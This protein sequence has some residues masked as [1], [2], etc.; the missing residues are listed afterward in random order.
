MATLIVKSK[1]FANADWTTLMKMMERA[2]EMHTMTE[3]LM[4][5]NRRLHLH[6]RAAEKQ[7]DH[8]RGYVTQSPSSS[9]ERPLGIVWSE[10]VPEAGGETQGKKNEETEEDFGDNLEKVIASMDDKR[11]DS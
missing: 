1:R 7:V 8:M 5:E 6:M 3:R 2:Q 11:T 4:T 10:A 9:K